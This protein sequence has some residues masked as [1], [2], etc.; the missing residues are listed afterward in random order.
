MLKAVEKLS[1]IIEKTLQHLGRD[2]DYVFTKEH[3]VFILDS[4][5][6]KG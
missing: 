6:F 2:C 1:T 4:S 3:V 5:R